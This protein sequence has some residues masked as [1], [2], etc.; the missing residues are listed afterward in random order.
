MNR[1]ERRAK[2]RQGKLPKKEPVY[3]MTQSQIESLKSPP[4]LKKVVKHEINTQLLE[5]EKRYTL[6][7]DTMVLWTLHKYYGFGR[8]RLREFY[9]RMFKE[10]LYMRNRYELDDMYPERFKLK[11]ECGLDME[12]L[13]SE[14]FNPDGTFKAINEVS[15]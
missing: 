3:Y 8:T 14:L 2:E 6:D 9:L 7:L 5:A 1:R 11:E 4:E 10:H 13:Y 12:E 15:I